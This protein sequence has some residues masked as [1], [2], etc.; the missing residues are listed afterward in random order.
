MKKLSVLFLLTIGLIS[1]TQAQRFAYVD[2]EYILQNVP[3]YQQA[4]D[5][6][7][8]IS[9]VWQQEI[10][11]KKKE[12]DELYKE[13]QEERVLL[14]EKMRKKKEQEIEQKEKELKELREKRFGYEGD[15]FKKKQ[16]LIK[17]IQ[18]KVYEAI[19]SIA[20]RRRYDFILDKSA[21]STLLYTNKEYDKS[22]EVLEE[23]GY[24]PGQEEEEDEGK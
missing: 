17:P 4:Q 14:T 9:Q 12:I 2:V 6:I 3:E 21:G 13:Y 20:E 22:K 11:Q 15:L 5:K 1:F 18:D 16:E 10:E 19:K 7:D 8:S 24:T 23:L